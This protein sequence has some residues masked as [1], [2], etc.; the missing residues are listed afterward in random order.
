[1][2]EKIDKYYNSLDYKLLN[3][4]EEELESIKKHRLDD[5]DVT[6]DNY[7][8][9]FEQG[10]DLIRKERLP[11]ALMLE[12]LDQYSS[13]LEGLEGVD[14]SLE[15]LE[16]HDEVTKEKIKSLVLF[17]IQAVLIK[18]NAHLISELKS[19]NENY[20]ELIGLIT[21]E[22]KNMLTSIYGYNKILRRQ[23]E[24]QGVHETDEL[25]S[26][27]EKLT[28]KLFNMIDSLFKMSLSDKDEL[29]PQKS[30]VNLKEDVILPVEQELIPLLKKRKM[31][32]KYKIKPRKI[33]VLADNDFLQVVFRNLIENAVKYGYAES[34]INVEVK[35]DKKQ[36]DVSVINTGDG[37]PKEI[38]NELFQKFR[39]ADV[40][41]S[42]SGTGIGLFNVKNIVKKH[43][44]KINFESG[45]NNR[46][47][48]YFQIPVN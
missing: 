34:V 39:H 9:L 23:L 14:L 24:K 25:I 6:R 13:R 31:T 10:L 36:L 2:R 21:H 17:G 45:K 33:S 7:K 44:G 47:K 46:T 41:K 20:E 38:R 37:I 29:L 32:L 28:Y 11:K 5:V 43:G 40:G 42:K 48:F 15:N 12:I 1:M 30:M 27:I 18:E 3:L 22:F 16:N 19:S 26:T 4:K 8:D 35:S